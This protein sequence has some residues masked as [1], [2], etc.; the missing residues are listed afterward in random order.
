MNELGT[1]K[2][3]TIARQGFEDYYQKSGF[4]CKWYLSYK[5]GGEDNFKQG[6]GIILKDYLGYCVYMILET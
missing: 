6:H 4:Y 1:F 2:K 5:K 3:Q